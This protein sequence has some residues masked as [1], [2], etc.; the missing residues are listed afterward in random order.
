M[1]VLIMPLTLSVLL[2]NAL[3]AND[4]CCATRKDCKTSCTPVTKKDSMSTQLE[5]QI[6]KAATDPKAKSPVQGKVVTVHYTGWLAEKDAAGNTITGKKFDSSVDRGTP[7]QFSIGLGQVI[8][9]WDQGVMG[10]KVG[11]KR[12]LVI[13]AELGYGSRGAGGVIPPHAT[14]IFDVELLGVQE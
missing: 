14:L 3:V 13:P 6:L 1:K 11:E 12:R 10:M 2:S 8:K 5:T 4:T 9:G 7:F